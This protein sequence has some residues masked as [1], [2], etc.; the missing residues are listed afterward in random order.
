MSPFGFG[1]MSSF[2]DDD[3]ENGPDPLFLDEFIFYEEDDS[4]R[5]TCPNCGNRMKIRSD[6]E[7]VRCRNCDSKFRVN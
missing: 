1:P 6:A 5:G 4:Y 7:R 2:Y 3:F